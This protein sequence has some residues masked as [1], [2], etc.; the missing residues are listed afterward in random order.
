MPRVQYKNYKGIALMASDLRKNQTSSEKIVWD[1]LRRRQVLGYKFLR[2]HP[3]FY[4]VDRD[5]VEFYIADFYC[6]ELKLIIEVDGSFHNCSKDYDHERD[7]KLLNKGINVIRI[8][9]EET[10]NV[11]SLR[12][13]LV[14]IIEDILM[15]NTDNK[16]YVGAVEKVNFLC[17][18]PKSPSLAPPK[19]LREG[20]GLRK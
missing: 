5:W 1:I 10:E 18:T 12:S 8:K 4:R 20:E 13:K 7:S 14:N 16:S 15:Q 9:N 11:N 6:A 3:V 2:Q 19:R 17:Y